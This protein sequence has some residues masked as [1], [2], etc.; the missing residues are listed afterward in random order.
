MMLLVTGIL[1]G[2]G[3]WVLPE[4]W[5]LI[6]AHLLPPL[7]PGILAWRWKPVHFTDRFYQYYLLIV[8]FT[9]VFATV[10][11]LCTVIFL[12][13][14][15]PGSVEEYKKN[16][17]EVKITTTDKFK[18]KLSENFWKD[19]SDYQVLP[20]VDIMKGDNVRLKQSVV[21]KLIQHPGKM[22]VKLLK[23]GLLDRN[24]DIRYYSASGLIQLN[25]MFQK[26]FEDIRKKISE[27]PEN[28]E[29]TM[30]LAEMLDEY[31]FWE[32]PAADV[33]HNFREEA[34]QTYR[35]FLKH[36]PGH[37]DASYKLG[38]L[39]LRNKQT[40][41]ALEV[42]LAGY[43]N[44]PQS[45]LLISWI[46]E[47]YFAARQYEELQSFAFSC[48]TEQDVEEWTPQ[49]QDSLNF[50]AFESQILEADQGA[51]LQLI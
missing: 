5:N 23:G 48:V 45:N 31:Y 38:R 2:T 43:Q 28:H 46:A 51:H 1:Q 30:E 18:Y 8:P 47:A 37:E 22:S 35:K 13:R 4:P 29:L 36:V 33:A 16:I 50:W 19:D 11:A 44:N 12:G 34:E 17:L 20:F 32:L 39:L 21:D 26:T 49:L 24:P 15:K 3:L 9:G 41:D 27:D 6:Q 25:D 7:L 14:S 40:Q 42:L 10:G